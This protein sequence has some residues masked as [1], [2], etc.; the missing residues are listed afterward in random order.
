MATQSRVSTSIVRRTFRNSLATL[1][2]VK[3][4]F[5]SNATHDITNDICIF[6]DLLYSYIITLY[7]V[8]VWFWTTLL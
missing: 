6:Q 2:L 3:H 1:L 7:V 8:Y 5:E 4:L